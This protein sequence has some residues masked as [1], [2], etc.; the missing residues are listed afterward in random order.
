MEN[1][2]VS[3]TKI[4]EQ[5]HKAFFQWQMTKISDKSADNQSEASISLA[6]NNKGNALGGLA[7]ITQFNMINQNINDVALIRISQQQIS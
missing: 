6:Y 7:C 3:F 2:E 5:V 4:W 1:K